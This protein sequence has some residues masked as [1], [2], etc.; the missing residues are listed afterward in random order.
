MPAI[1]VIE[2]FYQLLVGFRSDV[3]VFFQQHVATAQA[4]DPPTIGINLAL[5]I[6][7]V[8]DELLA[9]VCDVD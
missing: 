1:W 9:E 4:K 8:S 3:H 7:A 2:Q 6:L 5:V